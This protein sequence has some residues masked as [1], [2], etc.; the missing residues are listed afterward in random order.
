MK[1]SPVGAN[2]ALEAKAKLDIGVIAQG[3]QQLVVLSAILTCVCLVASLG[4]L[5]NLHPLSWIPSIAT[6][7]LFWSTIRLQIRSQP[8]LDRALAGD[9]QISTDGKHVQLRTNALTLGDQEASLALERLIGHLIYRER[10]P[11]PD[12]LVRTGM[13]VDVSAAAI[14]EAERIAQEANLAA[15]RLRHDALAKISG[16]SAAPVQQPA[17]DAPATKPRAP[18]NVG[19]T[20][21]NDLESG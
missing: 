6:V 8:A 4:F 20:P 21:S 18:M 1:D 2:A 17:L 7:G 3:S 10:L 14:S 15:E 9:T 13:T 12:G 11:P 19:P 5:W 16:V